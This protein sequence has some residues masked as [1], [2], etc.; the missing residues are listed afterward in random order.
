[1]SKTLQADNAPRKGIPDW[2]RFMRREKAAQY[3]DISPSLL[4]RESA[5]GRLPKPVALTP[6]VRGWV[7]DD[8]DAA[9]DDRRMP[10]DPAS[11]WT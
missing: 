4:D 10:P 1:M 2:P 9:I 8:L 7:R 6:T 5:S 3:L 11:D